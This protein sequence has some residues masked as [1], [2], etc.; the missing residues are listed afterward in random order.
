M[1]LALDMI[2]FAHSIVQRS[3]EMQEAASSFI[4]ENV[5]R[6][7]RISFCR[8]VSALIS[9]DEMLQTSLDATPSF[10]SAGEFIQ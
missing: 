6:G 8:T 1:C 7:S 9:P 10:P 4:T 5:G 2:Y 3:K